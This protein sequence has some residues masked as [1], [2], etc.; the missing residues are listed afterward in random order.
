VRPG[1]VRLDGVVQLDRHE[2]VVVD[3]VDLQRGDD[4]GQRR[5]TEGHP[6]IMP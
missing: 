6:G 2:T 5:R 3:L 1:A 4:V